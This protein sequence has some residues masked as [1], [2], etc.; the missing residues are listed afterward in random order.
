[1]LHIIWLILKITGIILLS[2]LGIV[3]LLLAAVLFIP[4]R[5][6]ILLEKNL[7]I[8]FSGKISW[9]LGVLALSGAYDGKQ[10]Q[11]DIRLFGHSLLHRKPGRRKKR[12]EK[13]ERKDRTEKQTRTKEHRAE[14]KKQ[15]LS[16]TDSKSLEVKIE[17]DGQQAVAVVEDSKPKLS[18]Q[19]PVKAPVQKNEPIKEK[20]ENGLKRQLKQKLKQIRQIPGKLK[21]KVQSMNKAVHHAFSRAEDRKKQIEKYIDFWKLDVTQAAKEHVWK[22]A[23]YLFRHY[24]PHSIEGKLL[25]G[26]DDPATTGQV[27][28]ILCMLAVFSG[29]QLEVDG[30]FQNRVLEGK[31]AVKGHIR[32][33]HL[34]KSAVMLFADQNIRKTIKGFRTLGA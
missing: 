8:Q 16:L 30:D 17:P 11:M 13:A 34:A 3:L 10:M 1:M 2:V 25:I 26:F 24:I 27:L 31:L 7:Q 33:C 14:G 32:L 19:V 22:E 9:F 18:V 20:D 23:K 6:R 5:Y 15:P 29:N 12:K 4:V 28:G 21:K